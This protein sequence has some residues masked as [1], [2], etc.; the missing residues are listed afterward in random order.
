[1]N[2][3]SDVIPICKACEFGNWVMRLLFFTKQASGGNS[4]ELTL[5]V[6]VSATPV[7]VQQAYKVFNTLPGHGDA[8]IDFM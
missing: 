1:M 6:D 8:I 2:N 3:D 7:K 5:F 4:V